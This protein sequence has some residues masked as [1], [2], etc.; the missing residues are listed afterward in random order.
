[1]TH[2]KEPQSEPRQGAGFGWDLSEQTRGSQEGSEIQKVGILAG[3]YSGAE[4]GGTERSLQ[5]REGGKRGGG[6]VVK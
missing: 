6:T 3:L 5:H 4:A 1:M 2:P